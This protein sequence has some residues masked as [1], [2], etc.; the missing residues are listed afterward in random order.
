MGTKVDTTQ[1][2]AQATLARGFDKTALATCAGTGRR[3]ASVEQRIAVRPQD[4]PSTVTLDRGIGQQLGRR[5][6]HSALRAGHVALAEVVTADAQLATTGLSRDIQHCRVKEPDTVADGI[7]LPAH[8]AGAQAQGGHATTQHQVTT[9]LQAVG[10]EAHRTTG[11][12]TAG[13]HPGAGLLGHGGARDADLAT[14]LTGGHTTGVDQTRQ[15]RQATVAA[16]NDDAPGTLADAACLHH[17]VQIE[18]GVSKTC[19]GGGAQLNQATISAQAAQLLQPTD[20]AAVVAR[21]EEDQAVALHIHLHRGG[22]GQADAARV[23]LAGLHQAGRH[24]HHAAIRG[25]DAAFGLQYAGW[26][27]TT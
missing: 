23:D 9:G 7:N 20:Q 14:T 19:A 6:D 27:I 25:A 10:R 17:A 2:D 1:V 3:N 11:R 13:I 8:S 12:I 22:R 4:H 5:A 18:H 24:Q 26:P 21:I 15:P 16:V